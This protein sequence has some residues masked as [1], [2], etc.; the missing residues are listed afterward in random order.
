MVDKLLQMYTNLT[1]SESENIWKTH[2]EP[3]LHKKRKKGK[4]LLFN[5]A[6]IGEYPPQA[7]AVKDSSGLG[8][9]DMI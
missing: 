6:L 3:F 8:Q 5:T 7:T 4:T 1:D 9:S 2:L